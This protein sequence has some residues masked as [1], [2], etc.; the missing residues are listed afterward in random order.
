VPLTEAERQ[1]LA[2]RC[3]GYSGAEIEQAVVAARYSALSRHEPAG[4]KHI[5][6][7]L[8]ATRPLSVVMAE[9]VAALRD[10]AASRTVSVE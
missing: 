1:A 7:E 6:H 8:Q 5:A 4:A 3:A 9:Q 10:W 2:E